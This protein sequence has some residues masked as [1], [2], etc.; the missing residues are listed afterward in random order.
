MEGDI[1]VEKEIV[2]IVIVQISRIS[3]KDVYIF[4]QMLV[5]LKSLPKL[6]RNAM[7]IK[8]FYSIRICIPNKNAMLL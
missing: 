7:Y 1:T 3:F 6:K 5:T 2:F 4:L 8:C